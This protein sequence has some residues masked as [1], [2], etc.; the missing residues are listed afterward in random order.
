MDI[1]GS[2]Y[3]ESRT[4]GS[5][6]AS[7]KSVQSWKNPK[8]AP[9]EFQIANAQKNIISNLE[10]ASN[11]KVG[12]YDIEL[13]TA[14]AYADSG[15]RP[16]PSSSDENF[17]FRDVVDIVN[18]LH[19]LPIVNMVYRGITNDELHPM[20]QI[21]GGALYGGPVGAVT[22]TANAITKIQTGKDIGDHALSIAGLNKARPSPTEQHLNNIANK[23]DNA[24]RLED[25]P[26]TLNAMVSTS[27]PLRATQAYERAQ[28]AEGRTAGSMMV[29]KN[30]AASNSKNNEIPNVP[31]KAL[32]IM[33]EVTSLT[34]SAMPPRQ[35][36]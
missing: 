36:A 28:M 29:K 8:P 17:K 22:G 19:H 35:N 15:Q 5:P 14:N 1:S 30:W 32:P 31:L 34:I 24:Q 23:L 33:E 18:P 26:S 16:T 13:K 27:E 11:G 4:A 3:S 10:K 7:Y 20:S 9:A 21:L 6:R 25:L 12:R 2:Y